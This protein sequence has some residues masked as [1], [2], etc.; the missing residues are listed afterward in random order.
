MA[1]SANGIVTRLMSFDVPG[2]NVAERT[3]NAL[4]HLTVRRIQ[5]LF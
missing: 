2:E 4:F 5:K 3:P 1:A